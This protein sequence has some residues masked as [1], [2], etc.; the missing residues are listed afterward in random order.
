M[1]NRRFSYRKTKSELRESIWSIHMVKISDTVFFI[2]SF[3]LI[4]SKKSMRLTAIQ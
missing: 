2:F 3:N 1:L 4:Y